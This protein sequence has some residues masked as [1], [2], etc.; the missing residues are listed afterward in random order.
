MKVIR[1]W[2]VIVL[3]GLLSPVVFGS[4]A[5][6]AE[7]Q[8]TE[9]RFHFRFLPNP[10]PVADDP[11]IV[12]ATAIVN[13][14]TELKIIVDFGRRSWLIYE[15]RADRDHCR[16]QERVELGGA[17]TSRAPLLIDS[18]SSDCA[19]GPTTTIVRAGS[20]TFTLGSEGWKSEGAAALEK[21]LGPEMA[22]VIRTSIPMLARLNGFVRIVCD[23][24]KPLYGITCDQPL[25]TDGSY[26]VSKIPIDCAFDA[27]HGAPCPQ[28]A[29]ADPTP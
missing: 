11:R 17:E 24:M 21:E 28:P 20:Q 6:G 3:A 25:P 4:P 5:T 7:P 18:P 27:R 15:M 19:G 2:T 23:R 16:N 29:V 9:K 26:T 22:K 8:Q 1:H 13:S 12:R 10:A 14:G